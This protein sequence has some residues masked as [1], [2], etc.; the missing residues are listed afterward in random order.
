[1]KNNEKIIEKIM[2]VIIF[3]MLLGFFIMVPSSVSKFKN[4]YTQ[5]IPPNEDNVIYKCYEINK[6][7]TKYWDVKNNLFVWED[8][9]IENST[10]VNC[11]E[12]L[13]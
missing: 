9:Y 4:R 12:V 6:V 10:E 13:T 7:T 2:V 11:D 1:M 3:L 8:S 5:T